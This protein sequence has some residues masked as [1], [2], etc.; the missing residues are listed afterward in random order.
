MRDNPAAGLQLIAAIFERG[1]LAD[2]HLA[3]A[4]QAD[5]HRRLGQTDQARTA[6]QR[7]MQLTSAEP[8]KR[9]IERRLA[10]LK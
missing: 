2:Y 10:E 6:Y 9:F 8:Q 1:A 7:A 5:L 4:A 3:H